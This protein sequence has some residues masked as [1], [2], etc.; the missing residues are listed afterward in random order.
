MKPT[1]RE[2]H[3]H[4]QILLSLR[5]HVCACS[6]KYMFDECAGNV[7]IPWVIYILLKLYSKA[8]V[9]LCC[10]SSLYTENEIQGNEIEVTKFDWIY[11]CVHICLHIEKR[12]NND[13]CY[14]LNTCVNW[15]EW[16]W[17]ELKCS[18]YSS[19]SIEL[20]FG[21]KV[22]ACICVFHWTAYSWRS[23]FFRLCA[24]RNLFNGKKK[25]FCVWIPLK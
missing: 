10:I 5:V 6:C 11:L 14:S 7:A 18:P 19:M 12:L 21:C 9:A 23:F 15:I 1:Y 20:C 2:T 16:N 17:I 25:L 8:N 4:T 3:I 24:S 13:S 22:C